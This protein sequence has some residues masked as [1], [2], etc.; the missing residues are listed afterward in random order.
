MFHTHAL[1]QA[2]ACRGG[3]CKSRIPFPK[4]GRSL[5]GLHKRSA[6][7]KGGSCARQGR[8]PSGRLGFLALSS[9]ASRR[10]CFAS[11]N[12]DVSRGRATPNWDS[13]VGGLP[14]ICRKHVAQDVLCRSASH[15]HAAGPVLC[16]PYGRSAATCLA[17]SQDSLQ[18]CGRNLGSAP[19]HLQTRAPDGATYCHLPRRVTELRPFTHGSMQPSW[20]DQPVARSLNCGASIA[21][22]HGSNL[23]A[24]EMRVT[25]SWPLAENARKLF[26]KMVARD[27]IEPPTPAFSGRS[28]QYFQLLRAQVS[29][30]KYLQARGCVLV[31]GA[32]YGAR[33]LVR[34]RSRDR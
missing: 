31:A 25:L 19:P 14:R 6:E 33:I 13:A 1:A 34:S 9:P 15:S 4:G 5:P 22:L 2:H 18:G 17:L 28:M 8:S 27:G 30:P 20:W 11:W 23:D 10:K 12:A 21:S 24:G 29:M 3:K 32:E 26:K 16:W 7:D